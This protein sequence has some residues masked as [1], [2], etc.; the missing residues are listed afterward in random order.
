MKNL[1][2]DLIF[3]DNPISRSYLNILRNKRIKVNNIFYFSKKNL[4]PA[5]AHIFFN[6]HKNNYYPKKFLKDKN[7]KPILNDILDY[8]NYEQNYFEEMYD[9][10]NPGNHCNRLKVFKTENINSQ[11]VID[12]IRKTT[13][14]F[15]LNT[16]NKIYKEIFLTKKKF[17]HIHPAILPDFRGADASLW[18]LLL[19]N[20][21]GSTSFVMNEEIDKGQII[22]ISDVKDIFYLS[23]SIFKKFDINNIYR[24]WFSFVDP[25]IRNLQ[26]KKIISLNKDENYLLNI[27]KKTDEKNDKYYSFMDNQKKKEIFNKIFIK[28]D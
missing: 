28:E 25:L 7:L 22:N 3:F 15:L 27:P 8:F 5:S 11:F 21:I 10:Q 13:S 12:E 2:F 16:S 23:K 24:I 17:V 14:S 26:F 1:N 9:Y 4:L 20:K 6:F 19:R 18:F